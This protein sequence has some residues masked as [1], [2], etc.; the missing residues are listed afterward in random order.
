MLAEE[1]QAAVPFLSRD[2]IVQ[3]VLLDDPFDRVLDDRRAVHGAD[4]HEG[5]DFHLRHV[6]R[7]VVGHRTGSL[8]RP[9][10]SLVGIGVLS[11]SKGTDKGVRILDDVGLVLLELTQHVVPD[12]HGR[13]DDTR[14]RVLGKSVE[15]SRRILMLGAQP[16]DDV[17]DVALQLVKQS[18]SLAVDRCC[19]ILPEHRIEEPRAP[20][21]LILREPALAR[22]NVQL[23]RQV[24]DQ[25]TEHRRS[26][27]AEHGHHHNFTDLRLLESQF[28]GVLRTSAECTGVLQSDVV[29][30][31]TAEGLHYVSLLDHLKELDTKLFDVREQFN[32]LLR[33]AFADRVIYRREILS[34]DDLLFVSRLG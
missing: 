21:L 2:L 13:H 24:V 15:D 20:G 27:L 26:Q 23:F 29:V 16:L 9:D 4:T 14:A 8:A 10:L 17:E 34:H 11:L 30:R 12:E 6:A 5:V 22:L 31:I 33:K 19:E 3:A 32:R 1:L 25:L 18:S 7:L 28:V